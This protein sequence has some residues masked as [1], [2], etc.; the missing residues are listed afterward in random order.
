MI[1]VA[2]LPKQGAGVK[3]QIFYLTLK[4]MG[5]AGKK[6]WVVDGWV[7]KGSTFVPVGN[8]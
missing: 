4:K 5:A 6:R 7:P 8:G 2:L 3:S 1:E